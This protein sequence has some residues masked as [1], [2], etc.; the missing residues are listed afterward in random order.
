MR[1]STGVV[2]AV[3]MA[4]P[5]AYVTFR[6][7][8]TRRASLSVL[9]ILGSVPATAFFPLIALAHAPLRPGHGRRLRA[10]VLTGTFF[11]VMFNVLSGA[12]AIP[13]EMNEAAAVLGPPRAR[14]TCAACSCPPSCPAW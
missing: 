5:L 6:G 13:K 8:R 7:A 3:L 12:A 9:Q 2:L 4:V 11:Y 1:V 10:L 14:A